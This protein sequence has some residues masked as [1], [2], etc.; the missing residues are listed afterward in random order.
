MLCDTTPRRASVATNGLW[1][2]AACAWHEPTADACSVVSAHPSHS[3]SIK[4]IIP[5]FPLFYMRFPV[6]HSIYQVV[7]YF[8]SGGRRPE[9]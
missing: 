2:V 3:R 7:T 8:C 5:D 1:R 6:G 4:I 9:K